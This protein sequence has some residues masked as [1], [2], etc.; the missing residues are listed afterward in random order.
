MNTTD[1]ANRTKTIGTIDKGNREQIQV[2]LKLYNGNLLCDVRTYFISSED[3]KTI[4]WLPCKK[5]VSFNKSG[6]DKLI[7]FLQTVQ[8]L[9]SSVQQPKAEIK[10]SEETLSKIVANN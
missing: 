1:Q 10:I 4:T 2:N 9:M 5:G 8:T 3:G 6:L 7:P